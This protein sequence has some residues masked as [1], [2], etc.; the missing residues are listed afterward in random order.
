MI[1]GGQGL[2]NV[3]GIS[4]SVRTAGDLNT[5]SNGIQIS[6]QRN[7][8]APDLAPGATGSLLTLLYLVGVFA[9]GI[10]LSMSLFGVVLSRL[11]GSATASA[12][13]TRAAAIVTA[14]ASIGL[15]GFWVTQ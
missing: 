10:L 13:L 14:V 12:A 11:L 3:D 8:E 5:A 7:G 6:I 2:A 4:Q 15:G 1:I 9:V